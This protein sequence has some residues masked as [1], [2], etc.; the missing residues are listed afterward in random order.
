MMVAAMVL[1]V[2]HELLDMLLPDIYAH[3]L[4]GCGGNIKKSASPCYVLLNLM[5]P[6]RLPISEE[7]KCRPLNRD[8]K[9]EGLLFTRRLSAL[10]AGCIRA[11]RRA[12]ARFD[13]PTLR[14]ERIRRSR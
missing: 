14:P 2:P 4:L 9:A 8:E 10:V 5:Q 7:S 13:E 12:S 11:S 1:L 6:A 3:S